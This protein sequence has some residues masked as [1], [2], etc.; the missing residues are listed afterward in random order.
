LIATPS[1]DSEM[2]VPGQTTSRIWARERPGPALHEEDE[3]LVGLGLEGHGSPRAK[4]LPTLPVELE[5]P[6]RQ[7][8]GRHPGEAAVLS[9]TPL[10]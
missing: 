5:V 4:E 8:H 3:Q 1:V 6:E 9:R 2:K 7:R 10:A